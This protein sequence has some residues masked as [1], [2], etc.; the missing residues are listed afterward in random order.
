MSYKVGDKV[1]TPDGPGTLLVFEDYGN[2]PFQF[3]VGV[4][5]DNYP[6]KRIPNMFK[7]D[8]LYYFPEEISHSDTE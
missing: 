2:R 8:V 4:K 6:E 7:D 1:Y 3:R 5:H